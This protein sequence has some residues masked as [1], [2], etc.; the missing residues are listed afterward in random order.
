MK[1][2][3]HVSTEQLRKLKTNPEAPCVVVR[4]ADNIGEATLYREV[5]ILGPCVLKP[6]TLVPC[7]SI[8][9]ET[10]SPIEADGVIRG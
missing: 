10:E 6:C 8:A 7:V 9:I 1:R 2:I 5:K 4:D 3:I